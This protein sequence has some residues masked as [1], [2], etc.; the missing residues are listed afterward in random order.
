MK[1]KSA[2]VLSLY[3]A[4]ALIMSVMLVPSSNVFA[5]GGTSWYTYTVTY[6]P[7]GGSGGNRAY[8]VAA[9]TY[10]SVSNQ[11][12]TRSGYVFNGWNTR[13]DGYGTTYQNGS[14]IWVTG[15]TTLYAQW[16]TSGAAGAPIPPR[17]VRYHPNGGSGSQVAVSV[18]INTNHTILNQGFT[19]SG[20]MLTGYNTASNG[21]GTAYSVGSNLYV[22]TD[23][24]LFAMWDTVSP[25]D[26]L[27]LYHP[28]T[29]SGITGDGKMYKVPIY[30]YHTVLSQGYTKEGYMFIGYNT[31]SNGSG[32]AY[33][34]G[35]SL[36][37]TADTALFAM[38][39]IATPKDRVILYHPNGGSGSQVAVSVP[40]NTNHTVLN[41]GF[42]RSGYMLAGYNTASNGSGIAYPVGSNLY[43]TA[44][45]TLF[46]MWDAVTPK[47]RLILYHPNTSSGITGYGR[48]YKVPIYTYHTVLSQGYTREGYMFDG[49]NTAS[50]GS[51][52]AYPV[53]SSL[54]VTTDIAL[55]AMWK[56]AQF[57]ITYDSNDEN[58]P[59]WTSYTVDAFSNHTVFDQGFTKDGYTFVEWNT[60]P[61]GSGNALNNGHTF[62]VYSDVT[63]YAQWSRDPRSFT[64][65]YDAN[66]GTGGL[67]DVVL[68]G[69]DYFVKTAQETNL[70]KLSSDFLYW[71][72]SPIRDDAN[73]TNFYP[74]TKLEIDRDYYL[75]AI[76]RT[77]E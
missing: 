19:R 11:S 22:A 12:F 73:G 10:H 58:K 77:L 53:G 5:S 29:N 55:F 60:M 46:A 45:T 25:K 74:G 32:T 28:N 15:N 4:L 72:I 1:K 30:T 20:Y 17:T 39:E 63:L 42:T 2:R 8:S 9:N 41:Q 23:I 44:D 31:A 6:S 43:V 66:S 56:T 47:D 61:D 3:M 16:K 49:Y 67:V 35:S 57:T 48:M 18:P 76:W 38:W 34:V 65:T 54:Y 70:Y 71:S 21:S 7:N 33:P 59:D 14:Y 13:A 40:I 37:V 50:N 69:S 75:Y 26:R 24:T 27:I 36:Y 68:E 52:T 64:V 62:W 51:G